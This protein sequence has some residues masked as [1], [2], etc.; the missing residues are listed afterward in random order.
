[1]RKFNGY[2]RGVN[3]GGWLSQRIST[4]PE[5]MDSFI[6]EDDVKRIAGWGFDHVRLPVDYDVIEEDDGRPVESGHKHIEDCI[7]WCR[8]YGLNIVLDLHKSYGYMFDKGAVP[9]ADRFF[10]DQ[11]LQ[12]RFILTW[13]NLISRYGSDHDIIAF[14]LLNEVVNPLY[15][16]KWNDIADRAIDIIRS[17][18][19]DAI[20]ILGGVRNNSV[21]SVPTLRRPRD[22]RIVYN[23]HCYEPLCFTHQKAYWVDNSDFDL[24]YPGELSEYIEKSRL[25]GEDDIADVIEELGQTSGVEFFEKIFAPAIDYAKKMDAMLYCGE[26]GV[27][28]RAPAADAMRWIS[29][30]NEAFAKYGIG[31]ALWNYKEKDFGLIDRHYDGIRDDV[32]KTM[33]ISNES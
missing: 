26:Y 6:T 22:S 15:T 3:L 24:T 8:K 12:D 20:I 10:T 7:S 19:K 1:M 28:D 16:E 21:L 13:E 29:D 30:I 2:L 23:F 27:I 33:V 18:E 25:L 17:H 32:I 11:A 4:E 14:E 5:Y 9:D 31:R